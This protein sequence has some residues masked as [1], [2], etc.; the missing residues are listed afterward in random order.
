MRRRRGGEKEAYK[1]P[2]LQTPLG[3]QVQ[4]GHMVGHLVVVVVV[5][6]VVVYDCGYVVSGPVRVDGGCEWAATWARD[7]P[8]QPHT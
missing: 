6:K 3:L 5:L 7:S 1:V 2:V 4:L 8:S